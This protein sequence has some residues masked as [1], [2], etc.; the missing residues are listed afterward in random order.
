MGTKNRLAVG[1]VALVSALGGSAL[2]AEACNPS[3]K[4]YCQTRVGARTWCILPK[5]AHWSYNEAVN[6]DGARY[7]CEKTIYSSGGA[8]YQ[9]SC[10]YA[11]VSNSYGCPS[12]YLEP[13]IYN[14]YVASQN[15][16]GDTQ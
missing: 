5:T 6:N 2:V 9:Q 11:E 16:S 1:L 14:G 7:V 12:A 3:L 10:G 15:M 4:Y 8:T 13:L